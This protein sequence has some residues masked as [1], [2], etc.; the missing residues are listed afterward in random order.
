M[1][2]TSLLLFLFV[3]G[4]AGE[5]LFADVVILKRDLSQITGN[6]T[7]NAK[8]ISIKTSDGV[9]PI[10]IDQVFSIR[11]GTA[12]TDPA[13]SPAAP[14]SPQTRPPGTVQS[15]TLP[16]GTSITVRTIDAIDSQTGDTSREY[17][18]SLD[19][20]IVV[21][22]VTVV[23]AKAGA[24]LKIVE[25]KQAGRLK[26]SATLSLEIVALTVDGQRVVLKTADV[27][28]ASGGKGKDT[29]LD[30][31]VGT[32]AG[33]GIGAA[34]GG[35]VGCG[36][37]GAVGGAIGVATSMFTG[38]TVK[39]PPENRFTFKLAQPVDVMVAN[40]E[41]LLAG[42]LRRAEAHMEA[43]EFGDALKEYQA[44]LE[45]NG[46][47]SLVHYQAGLVFFRIRS[48]Q[49]AANEF[50]AA[51]TGDLDPKWVVVWANIR[52]GQIFDQSGQRDRAINK[53]TQA[54]QTGDNTYAAQSF[55]AG[56]LKTPCFTD[57]CPDTLT[58]HN[59]SVVTGNWLSADDNNIEFLTDHTPQTYAKS[60]VLVVTFGSG[61]SVLKYFPVIP[62][63][64]ATS[65]ATAVPTSPAAP[66]A[67]TAQA[68]RVVYG[69]EPEWL[70]AVYFRD[71]SGKFIPLERSTAAYLP[72]G[73]GYGYSPNRLYF[74]FYAMEGASSSVRFKSGQKMVFVVRLANGVDPRVFNLYPLVAKKGRRGT[75]LDPKTKALVKLTVNVSRVG[76]SSYGLIPE[77]ALP[78]GEYAFSP[79][80]SNDAYCFGIDP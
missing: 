29:I 56:Y 9:W 72:I 61:A 8:E 23:P 24:V 45:I 38:K 26:G 68:P 27:V 55:A 22:Q 44:A 63:A 11:F 2:K 77:A 16:M 31:A 67:A 59:G 3:C 12:E 4:L 10:P 80:G 50:L 25:I 60:D 13:P 71:E 15:T 41:S 65:V 73:A 21:N 53:Y 47:S 52:L 43:N 62:L 19:E 30:G 66:L 28:S 7:G 74:E 49:K 17:A 57:A 35:P 40:T 48:F 78:P 6:T 39:I 33:C 18:A 70:G 79:R 54:V 34:A 51:L 69:P 14:G 58:L 37:G 1:K 36:V 76:A 5:S 46:T 64:S 20:P 42:A 32:A 75:K